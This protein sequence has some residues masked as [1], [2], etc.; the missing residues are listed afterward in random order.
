MEIGSALDDT[1]MAW[2]GKLEYLNQRARAERVGRIM[3]WLGGCV[4]DRL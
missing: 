3:D 2:V 1:S 4:F